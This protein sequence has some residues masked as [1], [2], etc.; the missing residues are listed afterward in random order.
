MSRGVAL[1]LISARNLR[2]G[3]C[4]LDAGKYF[5][6]LLIISLLPTKGFF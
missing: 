1:K 2:C 4:V 3:L 6:T 5:Y